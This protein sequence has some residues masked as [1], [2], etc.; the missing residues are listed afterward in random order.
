MVNLSPVWGR[1]GTAPRIFN[2][3]TAWRCA[4]NPTLWQLYFRGKSPLWPLDRR[5]GEPQFRCEYLEKNHLPCWEL[6]LRFFCRT[7]SNVF[8]TLKGMIHTELRINIKP[9]FYMGGGCSKHVRK[10]N[11]LQN[12]EGKI[13]KWLF[14]RLRCTAIQA[15]IT[16]KTQ[17]FWIL[18]SYQ[19]IKLATFRTFIVLPSSW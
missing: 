11:C 6:S 14:K 7:L 8:V 17:F 2:L 15:V 1:G 13:W 5:L 3:G 19:L 18:M 10:Q 9:E 12:F 4:V 16:A